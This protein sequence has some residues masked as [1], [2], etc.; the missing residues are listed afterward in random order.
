MHAVRYHDHGGPEVLTVDEVE[1]P[2]PGPGEVVVAVE[3]AAVNPVDTYFREGAYEPAD[4]PWI[5]GSDCAG[6]VAAVG[7]GVDYAVG[8]RVFATGLGNWLQGTAA[9]A[10]LVPDSHLAALPD[11]VPFEDGAAVAL[12]GVTAFQSLIA[13]CSLEPG[14]RALV[15]GGSGG[16]GHVAVQLAAA[17][18]A[19]VTTTASPEYH[20]RLRELGADD[21][22]DYRRD[23]LADAVVDA[24]R[25]D[26]ILDH[27]LD[28]YL[29]LD[30]EV[31]AQGGRIAAIGNTE[32]D[33]TFEN[34]PRCRAKALS[35]HHVSMFNTPD[36]G[37]VLAR[38][39]VLLADGDLEAEIAGRYDLDEVAQ[40][41]R[42][43][44]GESVLGKLVVRP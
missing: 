13:A 9:E 37:D 32:P 19:R 34:V 3:A 33:A 5:P 2:T 25:P 14:E 31:T 40:A 39:A 41:Q 17:T 11:G 8:D 36:F 6:T 24:G 30:A 7:E 16:V 20:D 21:A 15:H 1:R 23:D 28:D 18:G 22:F 12:V 26:V 27:R 43:V 29:A 42:D 44:L 38:L 35:V 10:A 4:L